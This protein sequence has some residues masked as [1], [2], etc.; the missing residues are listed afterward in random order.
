MLRT[1]GTIDIEFYKKL[2]SDHVEPHFVLE[3]RWTAKRRNGGR[4]INASTEGY[5]R[6]ADARQNVEDI[7]GI[8]LTGLTGNATAPVYKY[9]L[10]KGPAKNSQT[11]HQDFR[12]TV[13]R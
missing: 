10:V 2:K 8:D 1:K 7:W 13:S 5:N 12:I 4:I 6:F 3:W 9:R 11:F